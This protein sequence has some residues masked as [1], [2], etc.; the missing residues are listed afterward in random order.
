MSIATESRIITPE[1]FY[2]MGDAARGYEL[3]NGEM[4]VM[5]MSAQSCWV[6]GQ[7]HLHLGNYAR[8]VTPGW[9]FP[10]ETG[11]RC[12][13]EDRSLVRKPDASW[14]ALSR[15]T[16]DQYEEEGFIEVVPDLVAEVISPN[17]SAPD[18]EEKIALWLTSGVHLVWEV[19]PG[20]QTVRVHRNKQPIAVLVA[21]DTLTAPDI[22]PGFA[23]PVAELF[24]VP[25]EPVAAPASPVT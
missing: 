7:L 21:G 24:R 1:E 14:I 16:R 11:Y 18:V 3:V 20:S 22:L 10:P 4:R 25:G 6:G 13:A 9:A 2:R 12:F 17:D 23:V 15:M 8:T 5:D 19:Y